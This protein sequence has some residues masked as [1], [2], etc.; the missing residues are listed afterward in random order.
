MTLEE[1]QLLEKLIETSEYP[2]LLKELVTK[3]RYEKIN[4]EID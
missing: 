3:F 4:L 2:E 1:T